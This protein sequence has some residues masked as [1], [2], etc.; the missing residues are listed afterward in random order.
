VLED[1]PPALFRSRTVGGGD[2]VRGDSADHLSAAAPDQG[3]RRLIDLDHPTVL[4]D[5]AHRVRRVVEDEP[6]R[7]LPLGAGAGPQHGSSIGVETQPMFVITCLI[8]V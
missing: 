2:E 1:L 7:A 5:Q 8:W 3:E 6:E 4:V